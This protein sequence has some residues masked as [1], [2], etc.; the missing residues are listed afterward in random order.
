MRAQI[1]HDKVF[2]CFKVS[3]LLFL[4]PMEAGNLDFNTENVASVLYTFILLNLYSN[5]VTFWC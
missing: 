3:E 1:L 5:F 4:D 2:F